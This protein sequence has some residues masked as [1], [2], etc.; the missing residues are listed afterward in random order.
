MVQKVADNYSIW[1]WYINHNGLQILTYSDDLFVNCVGSVCTSMIKS[2]QGRGL[3]QLGGPIIHSFI[4]LTHAECDSSLP[5]SG[6][7]SI[8]LWYT[9]S[10]STLFQLVF[11]PPSL[12]LATD[13][14]VYLSALFLPNSYIILF[15]EFYFLPFSVHAQTKVIYL[16]LLSVIV[17]F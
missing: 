4:P 11:H 2:V 10:P 8:T 14:M 15:W 7:S 3:H 13:F 17:V 6:A 5:F 12:H 16:P 1:A 9:P